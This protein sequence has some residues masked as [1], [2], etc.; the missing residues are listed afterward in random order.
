MALVV[1]RL[2]EKLFQCA[3]VH[4]LRAD[5][6]AAANDDACRGGD[7]QL[8]PQSRFRSADEPGHAHLRSA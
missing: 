3:V 6:A 5:R 4:A 1:T 7:Q 8:I 2:A